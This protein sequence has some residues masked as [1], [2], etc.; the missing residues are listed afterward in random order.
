[1]H[2]YLLALIG[3]AMIGLSAVILMA[4]RGDIMGI[5]GIVSRLL[6][7]RP[8]DWSW[9][10]YF[11][12]GVLLAPLLYAGITGAMPTVE[13]TTNPLLLM[14]GG[15]LVGIGTVTGNGCTSGHGVCGLSRFSSRSLVATCTFMATAFATVFLTRHL[16]GV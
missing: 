4:I 2:D 12:T 15:L 10:V 7:P 5:S 3:G 14:S 1:M 9:R 8:A 6:P 13:I 11:I 16:L